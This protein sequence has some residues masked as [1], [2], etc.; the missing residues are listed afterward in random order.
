M[1]IISWAKQKFRNETTVD[2]NSQELLEWL[3][4]SSDIPK[5]KLSEVTYFTCLKMLGESLGKLPL[6]MYQNT[7]IGIQ[8]VVQNDIYNVLKLRPNPYMTAATFWSTIEYN[9][10]HYGNA[11]AWCR[12]KGAKLLDIWIMPSKD[13]D[14]IVDNVGY[15][16]KKGKVWYQY[17]DSHTGQQY[18]FPSD[19]VLHFKTSVT[20]DGIVGLS[21]RD[22]LKH[23]VEGNLESQIFM[24]NLFKQG[25]TGKAVIQYTGDLNDAAKKKIIKGIEEYANGSKN[26]GKIIPIPLGMQLQPLNIKLTDSQFFELKKYS[27]LQIAGA[28]GIKPNHIN[29]YEKSSYSNS[30]MQNLT[31]YVDTLLYILTQ[32]EQEITYKLLSS[33]KINEGYFF[34][35]NANAILRADTKTQAECLSK[36]V[37]NGIYTANEA[38]EYLDKPRLEGGDILM[39]NGNYIPITK[40][41]TQYVKGGEENS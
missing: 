34:K 32:Y 20:F 7:D 8:K 14:I 4:I 2:I 10:N 5:D 3:G 1:G 40:V 29:N 18:T 16:G 36:Y 22:I 38:R 37:N 33:Q 9:K 24:N 15:I 27:A 21:V 28:F 23:T 30:E 25:L 39:V 31:F 41:G 17:T 19:N 11:Y 35:F 13:V 26:A 6:K 12:Y